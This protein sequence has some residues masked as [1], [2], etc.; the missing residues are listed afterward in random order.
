[1]W[2]LW[3]DGWE[4]HTSNTLRRWQNY[5]QLKT[6]EWEPLVC[7]RLLLTLANSASC[8]LFR[9]LIKLLVKGGAHFT[10][11]LQAALLL[12]S[13][14]PQRSP[15]CWRCFS[16]TYLLIRRYCCVAV[17]WYWVGL[18]LISVRVQYV[19]VEQTASHHL[20][21]LLL[22]P[23]L[24]PFKRPVRC[25]FVTT[26]R[27]LMQLWDWCYD[28]RFCPACSNTDNIDWPS[29]VTARRLLP[30]LS[31]SI[32]NQISTRG[33]RKIQTCSKVWPQ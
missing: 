28:S 20:L 29:C 24:K 22:L 12:S 7:Y 11:P 19:Y 30:V 16:S 27:R 21:V 9:Y 32:V 8:W 6:T 31:P 18:I 14:Y 23:C 17:K 1:M 33:T 5:P 10:S 26:D 25:R 3:C 2:F 4:S 15:N 13:L